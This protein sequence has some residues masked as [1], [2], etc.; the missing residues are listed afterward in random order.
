MKN[1]RTVRRV[2]AGVVFVIAFG[3]Y[4]KTMAPTV[5]FWDC[6]EF[7]ATSYILGVP[8]PPGAP[9]YILVGRLFTFLPLWDEIA[10]RVNFT[11]VI[12]SAFTV[13]LLY[14][15]TIQ[16]IQLWSNRK[17]G[18][19]IDRTF[20]S[21]QFAMHV[22]GIVAALSLVF[23]DT[24]W[25]NAVEAEVY[26]GSMLFT[27]L[28]IWL[29]LQWMEQHEQPR[30]DRLLL[31][32]A[33]LFG[34]G[35]G[36]HL[37]CWLTMPTIGLLILFTD[38]RPLKNP[39]FWVVSVLLF[40]LGYSTY[41]SL[42][43]RA[44]LNPAINEND[45]YNWTNFMQFLQRKQYGE[46]STL[47][48]MFH[49]KAGWGYQMGDMFIKYFLE[50]FPLSVLRLKLTFRA[51]TENIPYVV[52]LPLIPLA[53]GFGGM[54]LHVK[55]DLHR[56]LSFIGLFLIM[57]LGLVIYL[58]MPDPQPRER[59]YV[60][61]GAFASFAMWMGMGATG[62]IDDLN[63]RLNR[64]AS[65]PTPVTVAVGVVLVLVPFYFFTANYHTHDRTGNFIAHDYAYN[66][67][68]TCD[69][70]GIIFTNGD[71]DT[72]PL[73]FLQEVKGIRKDVR[74]INLSLLNTTWYIK[75]L[76]DYEPRV[77]IHLSDE[78][79]DNE[80]N[81]RPWPSKE[82]SIS[83]ITWKLKG[84]GTY[85]GIHYFRV[86]DLMVIRI[87][88]QNNW[89]RPIYFAVTVSSQNKIG[90]EPYLSMEGMAY[91]LVKTKGKDQLSV[92]QSR[93]NLWE[94]YTY[95]GIKD[96]KV[97]KDANTVKLLGN[98]RAAFLQL[99][100]TYMGKGQFDQAF[101]AIQRCDE[102]VEL[103]WQ[104]YWAAADIARRAGRNE[105]GIAYLEKA[106]E[107]RG[108]ADPEMMMSFAQL[109]YELHDTNRAIRIYENII[110]YDPTSLRAY[111]GLALLREK[112][113][114]VQGAIEALEQLSA[115]HPGDQQIQKQIEKLK[116]RLNKKKSSGGE[117]PSPQPSQP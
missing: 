84:G 62:L 104:G 46:E 48:A 77:P 25:F 99:A 74:V 110:Q 107:A 38:R 6:G 11:S 22:G 49:R 63:R 106:M 93:R 75:Q 24:F 80:L 67:L 13:M 92:E 71:N 81:P 31:F 43:V 37:L 70:D 69:K 36:L 109:A 73:W 55:R 30:R 47:L 14:L 117:A 41:Y 82:M 89:K 35:G 2:I 57:G 108:P 44:G 87:I 29:T 59:D 15:I 85:Q 83:G 68:Q 12:A 100:Y 79:I 53:L 26:A 86:Q 32:I 19:G 66:I 33:Y 56:A 39:S 40:I 17:T 5:P 3:I 96:P 10:A 45:P 103:G 52:T 34:L 28:G 116:V 98:Y 7:I 65:A 58:N 1:P 20:P 8:H 51:A 60:F 102:V 16:L 114:D 76:R 23:S 4:L 42:M 21:G 94:V 113:G 101:E 95:R 78:Y 97:Y 88:Q 27:M 50:Q 90:L 91:R 64:S 18:A 111:Y 9:L 105:E 61:V 72:F 54:V 112:Q 115:R